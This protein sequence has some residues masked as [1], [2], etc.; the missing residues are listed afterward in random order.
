MPYHDMLVKLYD[1]NNDWHDIYSSLKGQD[2]KIR[3]PIGPEKHCLIKWAGDNFSSGWASELDM[4][5]SNRPVSCFI[6]QQESAILGFACYD[7]AALGF[8]GPLGVIRSARSKGIGRALTRACL[9]DMRLKGY[10]YAIIGMAESAEFYKKV[11]GA[12]EIPDSSPGIY[13]ACIA[14]KPQSS[15]G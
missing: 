7:A 8:F 5:L 2:V 12:I 14:L 3:K 1:V 11:A 9:L 13:R 15:S 4:A 6:A 10:G